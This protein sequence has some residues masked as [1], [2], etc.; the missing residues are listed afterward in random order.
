MKRLFIL[1]VVIFTFNAGYSQIM[2]FH[3]HH[4]H[5]IT[6]TEDFNAIGSGTIPCL[7]LIVW[8]MDDNTFDIINKTEQKV[9]YKIFG[10]IEI[11]KNNQGISLSCP[12]V[13]SQYRKGTIKVTLPKLEVF[14]KDQQVYFSVQIGDVATFYKTQCTKVLNNIHK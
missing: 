8:N 5:Q 12:V 13:D 6:I 11:E 2:F 4:M 1:L 3:A 7:Y 10:K 9:T 14:K